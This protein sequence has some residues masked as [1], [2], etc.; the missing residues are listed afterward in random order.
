MYTKHLSGGGL[1]GLWAKT[2]A[3]ERDCLS[4]I[5]EHR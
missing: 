4:S 5:A 1:D 2:L 3:T